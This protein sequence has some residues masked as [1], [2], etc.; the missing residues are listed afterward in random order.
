MDDG[1]P[2]INEELSAIQ[3]ALTVPKGQMNKFGGYAYRSA[4]DILQALK[5]L[6][7]ATG[8][9]IVLTDEMVAVGER[10]YVKATATY[11]IRADIRTATGFAREAETKKGMDVSQVTGAASSYARKY[12]LNG[13]FM[14]D[15]SKDSD[16]TNTHGLSVAY[17]GRLQDIKD[18][19]PTK[20]IRA[21]MKDYDIEK[22]TDLP[23]IECDNF[24]GLI[25]GLAQSENDQAL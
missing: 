10:I 16:E 15:D 18:S 13:L 23:E 4:E 3:Q 12:A 14:I 6:L 5:P 9:T 2:T 1:T 17:V 21:A 11:A 20:I 8:A 7:S 25:K 19:Y 24:E 22:M